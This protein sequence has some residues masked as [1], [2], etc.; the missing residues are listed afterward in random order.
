MYG[1]IGKKL[2]HSFS[3][4]FFNEKFK[5]EGIKEE[6]L[7]LPI[8]E[9]S[10]FP[11]LLVKY[12]DLHG[13]NVTIP[14][15][16]EVMPFLSE[17]SE[18]AEEIG[19][20]NT[21]KITGD[22]GKIKLK[23]YNTDV[24]GFRESLKPLLRPE[25]KKALVLGSGGASK[26]VVYVLKKAGITPTLVSRNPHPDNLS[27]HD[28]D[29]RIMEENLLIVNTTPLGMFPDVDSYPPIPYHLLTDRHICFDLVYNPLETEFM[30]KSA[31][32]GAQTKNGIEM[33][34]GQA[35]ASWDI[36]N[37]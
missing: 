32:M 3:A 17:I 33:L 21:I 24:I 31:K 35:I 4:Q 13:L 5:R 16:Q 36:W 25:I 15:K 11:E 23:G 7:L 26:A 34:H 9:I 27:Y 6:Y 29:K 10:D 37:S 19:A 14:Y 12:P 22:N 20:V 30:K 8:P 18:D 2:G 28:L 1:L